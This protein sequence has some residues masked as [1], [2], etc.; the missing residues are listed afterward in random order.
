MTK[1]N[2]SKLNF[3]S[4]S[5]QKTSQST[6]STS[7]SQASKSFRATTQTVI[8]ESDEDN[9]KANDPN[10]VT[11]NEGSGDNNENANDV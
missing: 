4:L 3:R 9:N 8:L 7:T 1:S 11:D 6:S 10:F 2:N 5:S